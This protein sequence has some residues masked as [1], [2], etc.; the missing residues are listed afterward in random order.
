[1][2]T[3]TDHST[4]PAIT[5]TFMLEYHKLEVSGCFIYLKP[6]VRN[7]ISHSNFN[8]KSLKFSWKGFLSES[9]SL[10]RRHLKTFPLPTKLNASKCL[11]I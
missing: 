4:A 5:M 8:V 3:G 7:T 1:M 6:D 10:S 2:C 9:S 11:N